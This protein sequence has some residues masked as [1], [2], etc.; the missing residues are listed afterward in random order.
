MHNLN[1]PAKSVLYSANLIL[2]FIC[3]LCKVGYK[4]DEDK[5]WTVDVSGLKSNLEE[6]RKHCEPRIMVVINPGNPTG[7]DPYNLTTNIKSQ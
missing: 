1:L 5:N 7:N 2:H 4:L 3:V 6:A